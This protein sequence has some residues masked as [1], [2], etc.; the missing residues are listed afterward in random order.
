MGGI[1]QDS[2]NSGFEVLHELHQV[3]FKFMVRYSSYR[4]LKID[5]GIEL[6]MRH[7]LYSAH[8]QHDNRDIEVLNQNIV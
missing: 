7:S 1:A 4:S 2:P 3:T 5:K 6:A 8:I